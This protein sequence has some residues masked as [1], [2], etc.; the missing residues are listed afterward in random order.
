MVVYFSK[1]QQ[2]QTQALKEKITEE[3]D[4]GIGSQEKWEK[5]VP[6][7]PFRYGFI[8]TSDIDLSISYSIIIS[9]IITLYLVC[10]RLLNQGV[11]IRS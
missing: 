5:F 10:L 6:S 11:G 2:K 3:I 8:G 9:F 7:Y 1:K 4:K